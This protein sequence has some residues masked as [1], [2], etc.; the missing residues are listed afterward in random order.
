[1]CTSL[2]YQNTVLYN[3]TRN[4]FTL[5][6]SRPPSLPPLQISVKLTQGLLVTVSTLVYL[7]TGQAALCQ[8]ARWIC[9]LSFAFEMEQFASSVTRY[10]NF[11]I[12]RCVRPSATKGLRFC[13]GPRRPWYIGVILPFGH[14]STSLP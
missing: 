8:D 14:R 5:P 3:N 10:S 11:A 13:R 1:M 12:P 4:L 7:H 2:I 9:P 6:R